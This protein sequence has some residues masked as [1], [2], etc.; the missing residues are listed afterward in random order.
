MSTKTALSMSL[1][2]AI[3]KLLSKK[4]AANAFIEMRFQRYDLG[5]K[6]DEEGNPILLFM[7]KKDPSGKIR[8]HRYSRRLVKDTHGNIVKD[9]WD[10]KGTAG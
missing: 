4:Y 5:F 1:G 9:H 10:D 3:L 2:P 7:G 6:T 8:S